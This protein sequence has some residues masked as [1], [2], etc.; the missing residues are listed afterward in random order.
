MARV[1]WR[2]RLLVLAAAALLSVILLVLA[3]V[4]TA[5]ALDAAYFSLIGDV[6]L[7]A[8]A[9][10]VTLL[11]A[12]L[13]LWGIVRLALRPRRVRSRAPAASDDVLQE[14]IALA[15]RQP[16]LAAA[17]ALAAGIAASRSDAADSLIAAAVARPSRAKVP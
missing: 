17:A 3:L 16:L 13:L 10:A 5:Q 6:A 2:G 8:T 12:I 9:T 15:M 7:A 4:F 11:L 14:G 1:A